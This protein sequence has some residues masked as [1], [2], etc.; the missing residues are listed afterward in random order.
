MYRR[1]W[2]PALLMSAL[3]PVI[4]MYFFKLAGIYD[5]SRI[6][7][8]VT[9]NAVLSLV[10]G[11][12][13]TLAERLSWAKVNNEVEYY[14]ALPVQRWML[15]SSVLV[16]AALSSLPSVLVVLIA[17]S[18]LYD[19]HFHLSLGFFVIALLSML[20]MTG[21]G[22]AIGVFSPNPS[23]AA[24]LTNFVLGVTLLLSPVFVPTETL[25]PA[26]AYLSSIM[27]LTYAAHGLR[28]VLFSG[29]F[30]LHDAA[31]LAISSIVLGYISTVR[32]DWRQ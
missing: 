19:V 3:F 12:V 13:T 31:M 15:S 9:G 32:M 7:Y 24:L 8:L 28:T 2:V 1:L 30:P 29:V 20:S 25:A 16:I 18:Q 17:G 14:G 22:A 10:F 23:V 4:M 21:V 27:P 6:A 26:L 5:S 11:P